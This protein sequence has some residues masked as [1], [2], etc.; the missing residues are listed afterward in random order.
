MKKAK[1]IESGVPLPSLQK[2][3]GFF[4]ISIPDEVNYDVTLCQCY[5]C[6]KHKKKERAKTLMKLSR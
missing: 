3:T 5:Y 1:G 6:D 4:N 2:V